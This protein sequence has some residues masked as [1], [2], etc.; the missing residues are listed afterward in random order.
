M[1]E[2]VVLVDLE[3]L[4]GDSV[5]QKRQLNSLRNEM[6]WW[7]IV[8]WQWLEANYGLPDHLQLDLSRTGGGW[9]ARLEPEEDWFTGYRAPGAV[10]QCS[11]SRERCLRGGRRCGLADSSGPGNGSPS[12]SSRRPW[13]G[14]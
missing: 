6:G 13:S 9:Q 1:M 8:C 12:A 5:D 11:P 2:T 4:E 14:R 3:M 7:G 10:Y